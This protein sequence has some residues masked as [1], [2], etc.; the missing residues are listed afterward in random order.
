MRGDVSLCLVLASISSSPSR[1]RE[2][3]AARAKR[4][5]QEE[6]KRRLEAER[7]RLQDAVAPYT[8]KVS[9]DFSSRQ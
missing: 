7:K 5:E 9:T 6:N 8:E 3:E 2:E 1:R 4:T